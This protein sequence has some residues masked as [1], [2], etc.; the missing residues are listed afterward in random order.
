MS[1]HKV[2]IVQFPQTRVAVLEHRGAPA[3]IGRSVGRFI[4]WRKQAHLPPR[5]N[6]TFNILHDDPA[7]TA[8]EA[9]RLDL[10]VATE[11]E[12]APNQDGIHAKII[13]AGRCALLRS[14]GSDDRLEEALTY[15]YRTWLPASGEELRDFPPVVQRYP[16]MPESEAVLDIYMPLE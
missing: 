16:E 15:L 2:C 5:T 10:C 6:A 4:A 7:I 9:F 11:G 3:L 8:P 13:P 1:D 14:A 12:I